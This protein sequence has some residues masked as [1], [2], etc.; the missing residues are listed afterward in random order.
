MQN[1][2][3]E[4]NIHAAPTALPI[5]YTDTILMNVNEDGVIIDICQ[6]GVVQNQIQ[7]VTR[8]GMSKNHAKKFVKKLSE[9]LA[10]TS[11]R[12]DSTTDN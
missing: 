7:I 1:P 5:L 8:V 10:L 3:Q 2:K 12:P 9:I 4:E 6:K 11:S